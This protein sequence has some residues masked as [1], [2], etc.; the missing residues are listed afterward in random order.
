MK[1]KL[2]IEAEAGSQG[3]HVYEFPGCHLNDRK[4]GV[5]SKFQTSDGAGSGSEEEG[6][7][8]NADKMFGFRSPKDKKRLKE[9]DSKN[10]DTIRKLA[11]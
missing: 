4:T 8:V 1:F 11:P 10:I 2:W 7:S 6:P 3:L 9:R 5:R